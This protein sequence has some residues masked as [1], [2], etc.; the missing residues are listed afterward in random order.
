MKG[1]EKQKERKGKGE[2]IGED[3]ERRRERRTIAHGANRAPKHRED[4]L[5][6]VFLERGATAS[7]CVL[8]FL[9]LSH[10]PDDIL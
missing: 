10:P 2:G 1:R 3:E 5:S 8:T 7:K 6:R 4:E 9:H